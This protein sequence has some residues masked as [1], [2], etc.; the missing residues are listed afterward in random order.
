MVVTE[1]KNDNNDTQSD[2]NSKS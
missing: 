1:Y 2:V